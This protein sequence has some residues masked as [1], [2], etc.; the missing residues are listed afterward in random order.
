MHLLQLSVTHECVWVLIFLLWMF[1]I[2]PT[3]TLIMRW[4][5]WNFWMEQ[6]KFNRFLHQSEHFKRIF[7]YLVRTF[8]WR[9]SKCGQLWFLGANF[10]GQ[11]W[12][13]IFL[14]IFFLPKF[15]ITRVT[16]INDDRISIIS[17]KVREGLL[18]GSIWRTVLL[19]LHF[20]QIV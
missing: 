4:L 20:E 6:L 2:I 7:W 15:S 5:S 11:K 12:H 18:F 10:R 9:L 16:S 8:D 19:N 17:K 13:C 1:S 3:Y 14:K